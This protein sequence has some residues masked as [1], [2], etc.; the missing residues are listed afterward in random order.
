MSMKLGRVQLQ[1]MRVLWK[2]KEATAREVTDDMSAQEPIAHSTVQTLLRQ[3][4][5]KG[6]VAHE[7]RERTFVFRPLIQ[8]DAVSRS[9]LRDVLD[10]VFQGSVVGLVSHLLDNEDVS[11]EELDRLRCL[12]DEKKEE[13]A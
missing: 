13:E 6:A 5:T 1:I 12:I 7:R 3:L 8:E 11:P 4:E 10:R 2:R 9:S